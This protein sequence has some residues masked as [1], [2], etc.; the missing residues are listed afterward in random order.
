MDIVSLHL[1]K[2]KLDCLLS[3][4]LLL[5]YTGI[6]YALELLQPHPPSLCVYTVEPLNN[7]TFGT[8]YSVHYREVPFFGGYKYVSTII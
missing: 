2:L 6:M 5:V 7:V 8:S 3:L 1:E 4:A